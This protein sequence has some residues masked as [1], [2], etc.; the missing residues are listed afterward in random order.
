MLASKVLSKSKV[1]CLLSWTR[2]ASSLWKIGFANSQ[3]ILWI[4]KIICE[5]AKSSNFANSRHFP[6][7]NGQNESNI[8]LLEKSFPNVAHENLNFFRFASEKIPF[9]NFSNQTTIS[10]RSMDKKLPSQIPP[11]K[12]PLTLAVTSINLI[13]WFLKNSAFSEL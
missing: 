9:L 12:P 13:S 1:H 2:S 4:R 10:K 3:I 6:T 5:F 7:K 8:C 11:N